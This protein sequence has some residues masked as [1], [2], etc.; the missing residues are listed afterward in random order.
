METQKQ[1]N[2]VMEKQIKNI[3]HGVVLP[4]AEQVEYRDGQY[5][6]IIR[7]SRDDGI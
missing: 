3:E 6:G 2:Y 7:K 5:V 1:E 4:L